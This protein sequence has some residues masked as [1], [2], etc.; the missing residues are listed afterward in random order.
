V[1]GVADFDSIVIPAQGRDT[2]PLL[3]RA[4]VVTRAVTSYVVRVSAS[5]PYENRVCTLT[6][7]ALDGTTATLSGSA[8]TTGSTTTISARQTETEAAASFFVDYIV[9][10]PAPGA[11]PARMLFRG[12]ATG[13]TSDLEHVTIE[14]QNPTTPAVICR[15]ANS[16]TQSVV[17]VTTEPSGGTVRWL[18]G[19]G[20]R[21][22]GPLVNVVS[23][24]PAVY[25]F[26]RPTALGADHEALFDCLVNGVSDSD[27][28]IIPAQGRD[29][30]PLLIRAQVIARSPTSFTVRIS[31]SAPYADRSCNITLLALDGTTATV[32]SVAVVANNVQTITQRQT[33]GDVGNASYFR[34]YVIARPPAFALP[35]RILWRGDAVGVTSDLEH[36]SIDPQD[37]PTPI[38]VVLEPVSYTETT[39]TFRATVEGTGANKQVQITSLHRT[40]LT[41]L[42]TNTLYASGTQFTVTRPTMVSEGEAS[43]VVEGRATDVTADFDT[44]IIPAQGQDLRRI[45]LRLVTE[46]EAAATQAQPAGTTV[47][48][49]AFIEDFPLMAASQY[50]IEA[51][52]GTVTPIGLQTP[53]L[54]AQGRLSVLFTALRPAAG[55][56]ADRLNVRAT[57]VGGV[58]VPDEDAIDI[59][60]RAKATVVVDTVRMVSLTLLATATQVTATYVWPLL[61]T[62]TTARIFVRETEG[63]PG[64]TPTP[65]ND[66]TGYTIPGMPIIRGTDAGGSVTIPVMR[67]GWF[68]TVTM[69]PYDELNRAGSPTTQRIQANASGV[70]LP[71][72]IITV[73]AASATQTTIT[74]TVTIPAS[75]NSGLGNAH[76]IQAYVDGVARGAPF[77]LGDN[78]IAGSTQSMTTTGLVPGTTYNLQYKMVRVN[79][80]ESA[81]LSGATTRTTTVAPTFGAGTITLLSGT[82]PAGLSVHFLE[83]NVAAGTNW[84]SGVYVSLVDLLSG[85]VVST[86]AVGVH[87]FPI[88]APAFLSNPRAYQLVA[89]AYDGPSVSPNSNTIT[90][91]IPPDDGTP[92]V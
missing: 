88:T 33:E 40:T 86:A 60:P 47:K 90:I 6:L 16:T 17:T 82:P 29:T 41:S 80:G 64:A 51:T 10:R 44:I 18:G 24:T 52:G 69:Q 27:S 8:V 76:S 21:F 87:S 13:V 32:N 12:D 9:Q 59:E 1:S 70:A 84:G 54:D 38:T 91:T 68:L 45:R 75:T 26:T 35:A 36:A 3:L 56:T 50:R 14:P 55:T 31:A 49:R 71:P 46:G 48:V 11:L 72:N 19:S 4:Q 61:A 30:V 2:V 22:S 57:A 39:E 92:D 65:L 63:N 85:D 81:A 67:P 78:F 79:V 42:N 74:D 43:V 83:I 7:L 73:V 34:D 25:T 62:M 58:R 20:V 77:A 53:I 15:V 37:P 23:N 66:L 5:A 89:R 28:V